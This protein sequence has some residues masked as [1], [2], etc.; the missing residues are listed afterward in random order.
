[1]G[2]GG[3][4]EQIPIVKTRTE[5]SCKREDEGSG[6]GAGGKRSERFIWVSGF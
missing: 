2:D 5:A 6:L 4:F 1:M 3:F